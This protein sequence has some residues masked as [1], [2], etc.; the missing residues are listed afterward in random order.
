MPYFISGTANL[1][2]NHVEKIAYNLCDP[3]AVEP[4][5]AVTV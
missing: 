1:H 3:D 5:L 4:S 2:K